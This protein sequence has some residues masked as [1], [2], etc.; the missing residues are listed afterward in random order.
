MSTKYFYVGIFLFLLSGLT[1]TMNA[2][3]V[4]VNN[5]RLFFNGAPG[6]RDA[7]EIVLTNPTNKKVLLQ[8]SFQDWVRDTFGIKQYSEAN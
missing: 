8:L 4:S 7:K 3:G 1:T 5:G 2:Q 6:E